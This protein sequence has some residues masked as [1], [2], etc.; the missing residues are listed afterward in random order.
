MALGRV[1]LPV[2]RAD[3]I[4]SRLGAE[5]QL[6]CTANASL[7]HPRKPVSVEGAPCRRPTCAHPPSRRPRTRGPG[8]A[9]DLIAT[10][11][12][13]TSSR[14]SSRPASVETR[15]A[16]PRCRSE[17]VARSSKLANATLACASVRQG[18]TTAPCRKGAVKPSRRRNPRTSADRFTDAE[19]GWRDGTLRSP[20][21]YGERAGRRPARPT[22]VRSPHA[23]IT[24][25]AV[26]ASA[27]GRFAPA[28]RARDWLGPNGARGSRRR[29]PARRG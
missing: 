19:C 12:A 6:T 9:R 15:N 5:A 10:S 8:L 14:S 11:A 2:F 16:A 28:P 22:G 1:G 21:R 13:R 20:V 3:G 29:R 18:P 27:G 24:H 7:F 23:Y 4:T 17:L 25:A 26:H